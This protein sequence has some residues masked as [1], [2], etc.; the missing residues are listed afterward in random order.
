MNGR[1]TVFA[2]LLLSASSLAVADIA[3]TGPAPGYETWTGCLER[4][5]AGDF[6]L[7]GATEPITLQQAGGMDRHLGRTVRVTG[8]W[9]NDPHGRRLRVAKIEYVAEGCAKGS[10]S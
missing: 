3:E 10:T 4:S 5:T 7:R 1:S 9:Q 8:R 6:V 2:L